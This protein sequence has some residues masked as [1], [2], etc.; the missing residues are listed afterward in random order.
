MSSNRTPCRVA[1]VCGLIIVLIALV[2]AF[3]SN[4]EYVKKEHFN[5]KKEVNIGNHYCAE[6][7]KEQYCGKCGRGTF[8]S[9]IILNDFHLQDAVLILEIK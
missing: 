9:I 4:V 8:V 2:V 1:T 3:S 6:C 5:N 7:V